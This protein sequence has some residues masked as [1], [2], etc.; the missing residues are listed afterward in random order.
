MEPVSV[1]K[2]LKEPEVAGAKIS[3][4]FELPDKPSIAV[5]PFI[6]MSGDLE[7][8]YFS[9]GITEDIITDLSKISGL[10]VIA[11]NSVF[12]FKGKTVKVRDVGR[13]LGIR[14]V[15]EG[16]VRKSKNRV[17]ITA[18]LID[19]TTEG[20]L[21]AERY[22]RD[23]DDIFDIQDEVTRK[24]VSTLSVKLKEDEQKRLA[25]KG[26]EDIKAYDFVLRGAEYLSK[27]TKVANAYAQQMFEKSINLD[28]KYA[29]AYSLMSLTH[30]LEWIFGWSQDPK[31]LERAF[32]LG[33]EAVL[34][35][36]SLAGAHL[37]LGMVH[38]WKKQHE[39]SIDEL[40]KVLSLEPNNADGYAMLGNAFTWAG[41]FEEAIE[42]VEKAI[43]L[44]PYHPAMYQFR[45]GQAYGLMGDHEIA[46]E[47]LK[48]ALNQDP[49]LLPVHA[50]LAFV[51]M[52]MGRKEEARAQMAEYMAQNPDYSQDVIRETFPLKDHVRL[53]S[54][55]ESLRKAGLK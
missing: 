22:D 7:Q 39:K 8:E 21:W 33:Q 5:L 25:R 35:D 1:Y 14:Y 50:F 46:V 11:R 13:E 41:R 40:E 31:S 43:R 28:P 23:L 24:I 54:I 42:A 32:K 38:L 12:T 15:L 20:H 34:L 36:D 18:Q 3:K 49:K 19:A 47:A 17:R 10:F 52:E 9:D 51:Y 48:T 16:S 26:T 27:Y 45:L 37:V 4:V 55:V 29:M 2:I 53:E 44:N 6:N 30:L